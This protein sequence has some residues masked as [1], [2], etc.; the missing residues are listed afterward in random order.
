MY[1]VIVVGGGPGG[2][3]A[4]KRCAQNGFKTLLLEK[5]RL[6]RE[7]VCTGVIMGV[8]AHDIV[9]QME[10]ALRGYKELATGSP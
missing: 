10:Y 6:P 3:V 7:K 1:D 5:K 4:A 2:S 8:W 9:E